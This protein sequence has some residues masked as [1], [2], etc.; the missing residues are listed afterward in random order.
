MSFIYFIFLYG[1]VSPYRATVILF[2]LSTGSSR[3]WKSPPPPRRERRTKGAMESPEVESPEV[4][5]PVAQEGSGET[6]VERVF[7]PAP[8]QMEE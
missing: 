5:T 7:E 3:V 8:E 2:P 1:L 6:E 4:E